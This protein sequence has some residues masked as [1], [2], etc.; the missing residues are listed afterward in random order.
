MD[1]HYVVQSVRTIT[2]SLDSNTS[3]F[4]V[5]NRSTVINLEVSSPNYLNYVSFFETLLQFIKQLQLMFWS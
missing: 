2:Y 3:T 4:S 1:H 5:L